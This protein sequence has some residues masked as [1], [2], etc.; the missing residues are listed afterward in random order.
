MCGHLSLQELT[1]SKNTL[2]KKSVV[3]HTLDE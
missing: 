1:K 2:K 3:F